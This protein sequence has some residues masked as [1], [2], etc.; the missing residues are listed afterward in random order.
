MRRFLRTSLRAQGYQVL[1]AVTGQ[2]AIA[3]VTASR[4]YVVLF[5]LGLLDLDALQV[6]RRT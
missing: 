6:L 2:E 4:P 5:D 1:Q 3:R